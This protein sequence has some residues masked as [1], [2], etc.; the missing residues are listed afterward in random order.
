M[1]I[2]RYSSSSAISTSSIDLP[3]PAPLRRQRA[4]G[5]ASSDDKRNR[6]AAIRYAAIR[7]RYTSRVPERMSQQDITAHEGVGGTY[8]AQ[9]KLLRFIA[10]R[11]YHVP[12]QD[13]RSI[14]HDV[15]VAY[16]RHRANVG[17]TRLWLAQAVRNAC[18]NYWR[19][20][21]SAEPVPDLV[22]PRQFLDDVTARIDA[23]R[24]LAD[25]SL[26][27][28]KLLW[29]RFVDGLLPA[30]IAEQCQITA[31]AARVRVHRC[32]EAIREAVARNGARE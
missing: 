17:N 29:L 10:T 4:M 6:D 12:A 8:D 7:P 15:F 5:E 1:R 16:L 3:P 21:K 13:V 28:Q 20:K 31:G 27:C 11:R 25:V 22:D 2:E 30:E 9:Y 19:D 24:L 32:L 14:I 23:A 26:D 18:R